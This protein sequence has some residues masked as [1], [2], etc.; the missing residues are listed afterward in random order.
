MPHTDGNRC[1]F[2]PVASLV[3]P[4]PYTSFVV[5]AAPQIAHRDG[6]RAAHRNH[7]HRSG[8]NPYGGKIPHTRTWTPFVGTEHRLY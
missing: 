4:I 3:T 1:E 8:S 6:P 5:P 2:C 7:Q